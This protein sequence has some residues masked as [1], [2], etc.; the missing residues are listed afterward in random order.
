M[1]I[2]PM[3]FFFCVDS[4]LYDE[5]VTRPDESYRVFVSN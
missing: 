1:D 4:G 5:L 2:R 3:C